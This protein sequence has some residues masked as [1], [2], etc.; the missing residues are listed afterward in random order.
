MEYAVDMG[1]I[2]RQPYTRSSIKT[3][4]AVQTLIGGWGGEEDIKTHIYTDSIV[5]A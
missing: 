2:A 3:G 1:N 5:I 4:S